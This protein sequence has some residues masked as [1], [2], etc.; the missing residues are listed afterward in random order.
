M[1]DIREKKKNKTIDAQRIVV[2]NDRM[3]WVII[4]IVLVNSGHQNKF[5]F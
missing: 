3:M 4:F 2:A 1:M 5:C